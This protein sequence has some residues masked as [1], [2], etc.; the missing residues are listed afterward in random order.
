MVK[1]SQTL[2]LEFYILTLIIGHI[3]GGVLLQKY[4]FIEPELFNRNEEPHPV[5]GSKVEL[6]DVN[7]SKNPKTIIFTMR[8]DC[9]PCR[10]S[11]AFYKH[12]IQTADKRRVRFVAALPTTKKESIF[13]LYNL[14]LTG[15]DVK[16][17]APDTLDV[18]NTPTLILTDDTGTVTDFWVGKLSPEEE[19]EVISKLDFSK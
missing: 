10:E 9:A 13:Y 19:N 3:I 11:A 1:I 14:G 16:Q 6:P 12:I 18:T 15:M 2:K 8:T 7:W 17:A 4:M 5:I